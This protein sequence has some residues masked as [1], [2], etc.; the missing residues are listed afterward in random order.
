MAED[1]QQPGVFAKRVADLTRTVADLT[2]ETKALREAVVI[3]AGCVERGGH[4]GPQPA[5][6]LEQ[7]LGGQAEGGSP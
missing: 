5:A 6:R 7:L 3:L 4:M 2:A 1:K